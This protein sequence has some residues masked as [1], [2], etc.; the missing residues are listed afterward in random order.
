MIYPQYMKKKCEEWNQDISSEIC[1][2]AELVG[3]FAL[4]HRRELDSKEITEYI[5]HAWG[6]ISVPLLTAHV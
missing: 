2:G 6:Q 4:Q 1:K 5:F 3:Y